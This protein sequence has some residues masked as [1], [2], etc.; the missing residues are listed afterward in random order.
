MKQ[1][2]KP[3][4]INGYMFCDTPD[5][6]YK[7]GIPYGKGSACPK[8]VFKS[9]LELIVDRKAGNLEGRR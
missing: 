6:P 1:C 8:E 2:Y 9:K 5:C 3:V 4:E 7:I